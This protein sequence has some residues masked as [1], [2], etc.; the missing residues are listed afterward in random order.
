MRVVIGILG[1]ISEIN[2]IPVEAVLAESQVEAFFRGVDRCRV[3][4][5]RAMEEVLD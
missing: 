5:F 4:I 1:V 2:T 3:R